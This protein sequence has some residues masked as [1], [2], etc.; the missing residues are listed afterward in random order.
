MRTTTTNEFSNST[1]RPIR[2]FHS[3]PDT[4]RYV[5]FMERQTMSAIAFQTDPNGFL[6]VSKHNTW[7]FL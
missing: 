3:N 6:M 1:I 2:L 4:V 5:P 7:N